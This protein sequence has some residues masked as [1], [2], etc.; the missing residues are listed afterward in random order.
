MMA[1]ITTPAAT[2][3]PIAS[4]APLP[5]MQI[6]LRDATGW[7]W[8][9]IPI[10]IIKP[11]SQDG[12]QMIIDSKG[13]INLFWDTYAGSRNAFIYY[14][15]F[16]AG[17]W[18]IPTPIA[19]TLGISQISRSTPVATSDGAIHVL[20]YNQLKLG[21]P[22]RLM[23]AKYDGTNWSSEV[24][25]YRSGDLNINGSLFSDT[26]SIVHAIIK[27]PND[28]LY[29]TNT[30]NG[31]QNQQSIVPKGFGN[32]VLWKYEPDSAGD[33]RLYGI[34]LSTSG[35]L[36][37]AYWQ[38]GVVTAQKTNITL[39][40]Y[41]YDFGDNLG[42]Y[43]IYSTGDVPIPGGT[44]TGAY[45]QCIDNH[46]TLWPQQLL[47]GAA[48]VITKPQISRS[49]SRTVM[50]WL[51]ND[52]QVQFLFPKGCGE[53]DLFEL[54]LPKVQFQRQPLSLAISDSPNKL[55]ILNKVLSDVEIYCADMP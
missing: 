38:N 49:A 55:C 44:T 33:V 32:L 31:W 46:L 5:Q 35:Q 47:S 7:N 30:V 19:Q 8:Y 9:A 26:H 18:T 36:D 6:Q 54:P 14:S 43:Y 3:A 45:Y 17:Q 12:P 2:P 10:P 23:Y 52:N 24:E 34:D 48:T 29:L 50:S 4:P 41:D 27:A 25:L 13:R 37:Y 20:W 42:N 51:T 11:A 15:I 53:A 16:D 1:C 22:Y 39:K 21:G 40:P 28:L